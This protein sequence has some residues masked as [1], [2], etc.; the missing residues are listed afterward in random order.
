MIKSSLPPLT[1]FAMARSGKPADVQARSIPG[2][3]TL[4]AIPNA[5][6]RADTDYDAELVIFGDI[7]ESWYGDTVSAADVVEQL[8]NI[9]ATSILVRINSYG[10]SVTDGTAI[11]NAL[12]AKGAKITTRV[13]GIAASIA[14]LIAMAG[15]RVEMFGNTLMMIHAPWTF[16]M[17]NSA[18]LR[19]L[20]DQLDTYAKAMSGNYA[21]KS[22]KSHDEIMSLLTDGK[23]HWYT[24]TEAREEKFADSVV[25]DD[26]EDAEEANARLQTV[27]AALTRYRTAPAAAL[28]SAGLHRIQIPAVAANPPP[29]QTPA[30]PAASPKASKEQRMWRALASTLGIDVTAAADDAAVR[31]LIARHFNLT[32]ANTDAEITAAAVASGRAAQPPPATNQPG[33]VALATGAEAIRGIFAAALLG[34]PAHA[35]LIALR[36]QANV[37]IAAG[38][39]PDIETMRTQVIALMTNTAT[40]AAGGYAPRVEAGQLEETETF[41]GATTEALLNR[42]NATAFPLT[43][44]ARSYRYSAL[45]DVADDCLRR[46]GTNTRGMSRNERAVRALHSTSDFPLLLGNTVERTLRS[47]Y[48]AQPQT[49]RGWARRATLPD[50]KEVTRLQIGGAPALKRVHEGAEYTYGTI[51]EGG[52]KYR[53]YKNGRIVGITWEIIINDDLGALTRIPQAFGASAADLESDE[54]YGVLLANAPLSDGIALFHADHGNLAGVGAIPSEATLNNAQVAMQ[55]QK[56]LDGRY[57]NLLPRFALAPPALSMTFQKLLALPI[58]SGKTADSNPFYGKLEPIIDPRLQGGYELPDGTLVAGSQT[59]WY[60]VADPARIDTIEYAYL[61]GYEGVST[62]T[63]PNPRNDSVDVKCRHIFGAAAIDYRG[64]WKNPGA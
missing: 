32:A 25:D 34:R 29:R 46:S 62:E 22:G 6:I 45:I 58:T 61:E 4:R 19:E 15:D 14:S 50:F 56:G 9:E 57:I 24:A 23:D 64:F 20:A 38:Q 16:G 26:S 48:D 8:S 35:E 53:V 1:A 52:K 17:G 43:E 27:A 59:A 30:A 55:G 63:I 28:A 60:E 3:I 10:G 40:S 7:G 54:V 39:M 33:A 49:F 21:R 12:R 42:I 47:S 51:A 31:E 2:Q 37:N 18:E 36:D 44:R 5:Q 41:R 13:E 11:Y